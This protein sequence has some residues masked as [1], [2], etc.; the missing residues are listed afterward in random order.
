MQI[1]TNSQF[2]DRL[3]SMARDK[4]FIDGGRVNTTALINAIAVGEVPIGDRQ[5]LDNAPW[6]PVLLE[7]I[8]NKQ[9]F[10]LNYTDAEGTSRNYKATYAQLTWR[11]K[12]L[13]LEIY[14]PAENQD[15]QKSALPEL[16]HNRCFR[17][18]RIVKDAGVLDLEEKWREDGL[19]T[20]EVTFDL[21]GGLAH[22]YNLQADELGIH[23]VRWIESEL[24]DPKLRVIRKISS[25]FWFLRSIASYGEKCE[26]VS[27]D[28]LREKAINNLKRLAKR[29]GLKVQ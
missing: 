23:S 15:Y 1:I 4:G 6:Y 16:V 9:P 7:K 14:D 25:D 8:A 24:Q 10:V 19:Q 3:K 2:D 12:R 28:I 29:Y 20:I 18:D 13:Y 11:E 26:I 22:S 27:P 17:V 21:F 5:Y